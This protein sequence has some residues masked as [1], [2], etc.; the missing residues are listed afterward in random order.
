MILLRVGGVNA[1]IQVMGLTRLLK[2]SYKFDFHFSLG[3]WGK[4]N[5]TKIMIC[6]VLNTKI[7][8]S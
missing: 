2:L 4:E 7:C 1:D 3:L 8:Q 5:L 6:I